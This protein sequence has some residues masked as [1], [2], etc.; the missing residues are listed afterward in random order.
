MHKILMYEL[1]RNSPVA[2]LIATIRGFNKALWLVL[3]V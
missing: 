2:V 1:L 3:L